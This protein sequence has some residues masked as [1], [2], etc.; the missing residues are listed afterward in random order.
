MVYPQA[1]EIGLKGVNNTRKQKYVNARYLY[2]NLCTPDE[3]SNFA[4]TSMLEEMTQS[5]T[6]ET[7]SNLIFC[8]PMSLMKLFI[9]PFHHHYF[10][11]TKINLTS[12]L[13]QKANSISGSK[14]RKNPHAKFYVK[15]VVLYH[16]Q[17]V[18]GL[19]SARVFEKI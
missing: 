12:T 17:A 7:F 9:Y 14:Q 5:I 8:Q 13:S 3:F 16:L 10:T 6:G 15:N 2:L 18:L 4:T 11:S 19:S 1:W